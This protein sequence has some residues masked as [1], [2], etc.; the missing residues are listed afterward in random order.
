VTSRKV[1]HKQAACETNCAHCYPKVAEVFD[2]DQGINRPSCGDVVRAED[3]GRDT[4]EIMLCEEDDD[5]L[6]HIC[7]NRYKT[8]MRAGERCMSVYQ[9]TSASLAGDETQ[10]IMSGL[11]E[12]RIK[13]DI[14]MT[15]SRYYSERNVVNEYFADLNT[16]TVRELLGKV[17]ADYDDIK[18]EG[19]II[20]ANG[21]FECTLLSSKCKAKWDFSRLDSN[22][23]GFGLTHRLFLPGVTLLGGINSK[24]TRYIFEMRGIRLL[25]SVSSKMYV[26]DPMAALIA[27][28]GVMGLAALSN[29]ITELVMAKIDPNKQRY[30]E[31]ITL[32]Y[33]SFVEQEKEQLKDAFDIAIA[34]HMKALY[35][36]EQ[37]MMRL[38]D[39]VAPETEQEAARF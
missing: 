31:F 37:Q 24:E 7:F 15:F 12:W 35:A 3:N 28:G 17:G 27:I 20:A 19:I 32:N 26:P 29:T 36:E 39:Q 4:K 1:F 8:D 11:D 34:K 22:S 23:A 6:P 10:F 18:M 13:F 21:N 25:A 16:W 5:G 38:L 30:T 14:F 33:E 2:L 9:S